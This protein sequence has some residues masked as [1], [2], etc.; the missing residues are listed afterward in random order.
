MFTAAVCLNIDNAFD[1]ICQLG[2]LYKLF[3]LKFSTIT[4]KLISSF[5]SQRKAKISVEGEISTPNDIKAWV[6]QCSVL[7]PTLYSLYINDTPQTPGVCL[8]LF[9]DDTY[10][11]IYVTVR[12]ERHDLR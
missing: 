6:L 1:K 7:S 8:G 3:Q 2:L 9:A 12:K 5:I 11:Y 10:I 4:I